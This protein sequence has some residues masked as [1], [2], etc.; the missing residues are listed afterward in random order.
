[1]RWSSTSKNRRK[2]QNVLLVEDHSEI[3]YDIRQ[4]LEDDY[5][6]IEVSHGLEAHDLFKLS[7]YDIILSELIMPYM[8][9]FKPIESI[10]KDPN[11]SKM[12]IL[13]VSVRMTEGDKG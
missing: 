4:I 6:I 7:K 10:S 8:D 5:D 9:G 2:K 3:T 13:V 12:L 11:F 1:M